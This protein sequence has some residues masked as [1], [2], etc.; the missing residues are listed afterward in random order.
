MSDILILGGT[1]WLGGATA[2]AALAAD[3]RVTCLARGSARQPPA[4]AE[5]VRADRRGPDAYRTVAGRDWDLVVEIAWQPGMVREALAELADRAAA[6]V[7]VSSI[8]VYAANDMAGADESDALLPAHAAAEAGMD[9]YG[10]A[11][12]ACEEA[13][14]LATGGRAM[15]ARAG[16]IGG[17]GDRSDRTGY[18][19]GRFAQAR[20]AGAGA[21]LVPDAPD[22]QVQIIDVLDLAGFLVTAGL[23]GRSGP[24]NVVGEAT[25]FTAVVDTADRCSGADGPEVRQ[26]RAD[27]EW[28]LAQGVSPWMGPRSLP[29][30]VPGAEAVGLSTR[31][32]ARAVAWGLRRRPL[33]DTLAAALAYE[34]RTGLDRDRRAGLAAADEQA[35]I[36]ALSR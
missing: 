12:V 2:S 13:T 1:A 7:M 10:E 25:A 35:L 23:D 19:P 14:A 34:R 22:G 6:W 32:D 9:E 4:G 16:L 30:W 18:W 21:V 36:T 15:L 5:F 17:D 8:S 26:V 11:K 31:S 29:L 33:A 3:H 28:L 24:V 20:S 27:P